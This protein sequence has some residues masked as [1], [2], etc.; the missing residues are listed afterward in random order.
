VLAYGGSWVDNF[1][2]VL[3]ATVSVNLLSGGGNPMALVA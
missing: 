2:V 3:V 1:F